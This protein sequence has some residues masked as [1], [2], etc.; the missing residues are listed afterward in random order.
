MVLIDV[1][2][3]FIGGLKRTLQTV[4]LSSLISLLFLPNLYEF[5]S[6]FETK[7]TN[8]LHERSARHGHSDEHHDHRHEMHHHHG[9]THDLDE[10][11]AFK[12]SREANERISADEKRNTQPADTQGAALAKR[13]TA[14][15]WISAMLS[16]LLISI[17]PFFILFFI[18]VDNSEKHQPLLKVLLSF[19][20]GGLLGDAFLHLIPHA[21][22]ARQALIENLTSS[23]HGHSHSHSH[24]HS[25]THGHAEDDHHEH[26]LFVG[27]WVL[28]GILI[29][30]MI[31]KFVRIVKGEHGHSHSHGHSHD[32]VH[33]KENKDEKIE[34]DAKEDTHNDKDPVDVPA[35]ETEI[36]TRENKTDLAANHKEEESEKNETAPITT[37]KKVRFDENPQVFVREPSF[38]NN[39]IKVAGYLNLA[40][41][42]THNLTD[43]LAIGASFL[44]GRSIGIVTAITIL[45]HEVPHEIGDY[46]ILIQ[47]GCSR[48]RA[49]MLQLVTALGA[50]SGTIL[51]LLADGM[52]DATSSW[53]L[54]FTAGGFIYIA[55]VSVIPELLEGTSLKQSIR[56]IFALI[57]GVILMVFIAQ[58]E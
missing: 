18:P 55:T 32:H 50:L 10:P 40:A 47:S 54:P 49:M 39:D 14:S 28:F 23:G 57:T 4:V 11:P 3:V 22:L 20:S 45:L 43:G 52:T 30:L 16:T 2:T 8:Y 38:V 48:R 1:K 35:D 46:A 21:L 56:E 19:A 31:E 5:H 33:T 51:S 6:D 24:S 53:I 12:Y 34:D 15:I 36:K 13:D 44:A 29:F 9:H 17:V 7:S 26:D 27:L 37:K 58:Y 25:H 42:F 41:D